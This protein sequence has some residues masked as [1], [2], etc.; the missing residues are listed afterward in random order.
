[1]LKRSAKNQMAKVL[2]ISGRTGAGKTTV[3]KRLSDELNAFRFSHDEVLKTVYGEEIENFELACSRVNRLILR[4]T[5]ELL[6]LDIP[7]VLEGWGGRRLRDELRRALDQLD[8]DYVFVF[9]DCHSRLRLRRVLNR[10]KE[11]NQEGCGVDEASFH[12]MEQIDEEFG[13]D[14]DCIVFDNSSSDGKLEVDSIINAAG[15]RPD[16]QN[17]TQH[18]KSDRAGESEA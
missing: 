12:R 7:I 1:M 13:A 5:S 9:V 4:Q 18:H 2:I 8:A 6:K 17:K 10:N 11:K 3:G 15:T 16:L 14:E